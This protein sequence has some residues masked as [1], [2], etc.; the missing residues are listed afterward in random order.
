MLTNSELLEF[1]VSHFFSKY[2][3]KRI[4]LHLTTF[5]A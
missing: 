3:I 4:V 1:I 2:I 5:L